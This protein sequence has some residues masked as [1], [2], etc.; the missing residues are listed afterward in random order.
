MVWTEITASDRSVQSTKKSL[1]IGSARLPI[2]RPTVRPSDCIYKLKHF[3]VCNS[4]L[5]LRQN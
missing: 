1:K 2:F 3:Y 5:A 4:V